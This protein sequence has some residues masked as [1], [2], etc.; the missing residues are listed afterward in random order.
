[1]AQSDQFQED[2]SLF[3]LDDKRTGI[4]VWGTVIS[5]LQEDD[6]SNG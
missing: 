5:K 6:G 2:H 4:Q 3:R 1:M